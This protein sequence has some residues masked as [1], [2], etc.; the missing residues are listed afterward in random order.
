MSA[1]C[2]LA[3][4]AFGSFCVAPMTTLTP[5]FYPLIHSVH[6][7]RL[8]GKLLFLKCEHICNWAFKLLLFLLRWNGDSYLG[9]AVLM[10]VDLH[11]S[12]VPYS[13]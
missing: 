12:Q 13:V 5:F 7:V 6:L 3:A 10:Q 8:T 2:V 11:H 9:P 4:G 1:F